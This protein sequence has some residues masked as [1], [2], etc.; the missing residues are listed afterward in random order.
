MIQ[1]PLDFRSI[2]AWLPRAD[3]LSASGSID[4][5]AITRIDSS[6]VSFLLELSR[7]AA[8]QGKALRFSHP[9]KNLRGLLEFLEV[10]AVLDVDR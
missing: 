6:G 2:E 10:D 8:A 3:A 5:S 7:R 4:L 1:G 9:P